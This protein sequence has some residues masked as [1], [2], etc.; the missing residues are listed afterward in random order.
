MKRE[1]IKEIVESKGYV[2]DG[3]VPFR[4]SDRIRWHNKNLKVSINLGKKIRD[5][6]REHFE[7][8]VK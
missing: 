7:M 3:I 4:H 8:W 6:P 1:E 2:F 5:I